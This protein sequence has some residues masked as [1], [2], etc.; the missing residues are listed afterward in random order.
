MQIQKLLTFFSKNI[1]VYAIFNDQNFDNT[2]TNEIVSFEQLGPGVYYVF[3]AFS[4]QFVFVYL[5]DV[6][7][8]IV[9]FVVAFS[10]FFF[11]FFFFFF[12]F[13]FYVVNQDYHC[14]LFFLVIAFLGIIL[15]SYFTTVL[16]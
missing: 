14:F 5:F 6:C 11:F 8:F 12:L 1:S 15:L 13:F 9:D 2:L 7:L 4:S 3:P 10:F 16:S